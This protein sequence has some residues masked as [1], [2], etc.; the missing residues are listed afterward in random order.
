MDQEPIHDSNALNESQVLLRAQHV[1]EKLDGSGYCLEC[2]VRVIT[3]F[4]G[5]PLPDH[6]LDELAEEAEL[7][8]L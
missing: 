5:V 7:D 6:R 4:K 1:H 8:L 3:S 2:G